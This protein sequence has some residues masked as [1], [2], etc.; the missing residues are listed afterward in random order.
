MIIYWCNRVTKVTGKIS[1]ISI[2]GHGFQLEVICRGDGTTLGGH[3]IYGTRRVRVP[4]ARQAAPCRPQDPRGGFLSL[5]EGLIEGDPLMGRRRNV[6]PSMYASRN[7]DVCRRFAVF[8]ICNQYCG[9][10]TNSNFI[11]VTELCS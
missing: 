11:S 9:Y 5:R 10:V 1:Y 8:R 7:V 3:K 2:C 6:V 4:E